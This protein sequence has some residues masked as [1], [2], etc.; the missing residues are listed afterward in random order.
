YRSFVLPQVAGRPGSP[1]LDEV[2]VSGG[3]VHNRTL[4]E[5][6]RRLLAP[7]PVREFNDRGVPADAK[8]AVAFALLA[9]EAIHASPANVPAATGAR[10]PAVLGKICLPPP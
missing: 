6:L 8:E 10:R 7:T 2:L 3:G 4:M 1:A 5:H 9:V